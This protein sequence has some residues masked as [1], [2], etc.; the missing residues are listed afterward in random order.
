MESLCDIFARYPTD[1]NTGHRYGPVYEE[2]LAPIRDQAWAVLEIGVARGGSLR[3][4]RDYFPKATVVGLDIDPSARFI[5]DRIVCVT[6]DQ[7][8]PYIV[9][10]VGDNYGPFDLIVDDGSHKIG[11]QMTSLLN[12]WEHLAADGVYVV[13][14]I[15][16]VAAYERVLGSFGQ[17]YDVRGVY[18]DVMFVLRK[19]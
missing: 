14:D 9:R 18:D 13:E 16:D 10:Q 2:L 12:L 15:Q 17:L 6:G 7:A 3:V 5:D 4:W 8:A 1:K 19:Q 11:D